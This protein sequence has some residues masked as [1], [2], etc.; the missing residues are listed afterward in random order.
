MPLQP[1]QVID[2]LPAQPDADQV[3]T[4]GTANNDIPAKLQQ[5]TVRTMGTSA[6]AACAAGRGCGAGLFSR[7]LPMPQ[8]QFVLWSSLP[9]V[10]GDQVLLQASSRDV[11]SMAL[12]WF[13]LPLL[14]MLTSAALTHWLLSMAA[15]SSTLWLD[16]GVLLALLA[17]LA[18]GWWLASRLAL[19]Q[20][21]EV[22][23]KR[24]CGEPAAIEE[25]PMDTN[26]AG[27]SDIK[28]R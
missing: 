13:G 21:A 20:Q 2:V 16:A 7:L 15:W 5:V 22:S 9:L 8:Q 12:I 27:K 23:I 25:T 1:A 10:P 24:A 19:L 28:H 11:E 4:A 26:I 17:G 18:A 6:C 3:T 14:L